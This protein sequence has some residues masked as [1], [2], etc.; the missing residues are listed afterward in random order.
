MPQPET[1]ENLSNITPDEVEARFPD[2]AQGFDNLRYLDISHMMSPDRAVSIIVHDFPEALRAHYD[3]VCIALKRGFPRA[4]FYVGITV[5][6]TEK[7]TDNARERGYLVEDRNLDENRVLKLAPTNV[8]QSD[9]IT[10]ALISRDSL[11]QIQ[12]KNRLL[13]RAFILQTQE[14]LANRF[15]NVTRIGTGYTSCVFL[16]EGTAVKVFSEIILTPEN[17]KQQRDLEVEILQRLHGGPFPQII[18]NLIDTIP[19]GIIGFPMTFIPGVNPV[20][21]ITD[22]AI[23]AIYHPTFKLPWDTR[24][25]RPLTPAQLEKGQEIIEKIIASAQS[26]ADFA[27][28]RGLALRDFRTENLLGFH[29]GRRQLE[30]AG[31]PL[32]FVDVGSAIELTE[33]AKRYDTEQLQALYSQLLETYRRIGSNVSS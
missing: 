24:I 21:Y 6:S 19:P 18:T 17:A 22:V 8:P 28:T 30:K 20:N 13:Q 27:Y 16:A 5:E 11:I 10:L 7:V 15:S 9:T 4:P 26:I 33:E 25:K 12:D 32:T 29:G 1:G 14:K 3:H 2:Y 23:D 31:F